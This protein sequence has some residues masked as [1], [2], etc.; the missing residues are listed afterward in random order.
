MCK[1]VM[2]EEAIE[3]AIRDA[4]LKIK[5][6]KCRP[7]SENIIK[8]IAK[9]TGLAIQHVKKHLRF[10]VEAGAIYITVTSRNEESYQIFDIKKFNESDIFQMITTNRI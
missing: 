6:G 3:K 10:L 7:H 8:N 1:K 9:N 5:R 4:I 2:D